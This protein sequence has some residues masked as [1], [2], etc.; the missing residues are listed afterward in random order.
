VTESRESTSRVAGR[1]AHLIAWPDPFDGHP[2]VMTGQTYRFGIG[3]AKYQEAAVAIFT[4]D[5]SGRVLSFDADAASKY[6]EIGASRR[7][8]GRPISQFDA[9]I[10]AITCSRGAALATRNA[11]GFEDCG[12]QVVNPWVE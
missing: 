5:F 1:S 10:A 4:D 12:I 6:A 9:V 2:R 7:A 8:V 3:R 11:K